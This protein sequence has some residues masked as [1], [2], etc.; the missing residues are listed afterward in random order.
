MG[1]GT[2]SHFTR[3]IRVV[4]TVAAPLAAEMVFAWAR[5]VLSVRSIQQ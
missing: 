1:V 4:S 2:G 3:C 5:N